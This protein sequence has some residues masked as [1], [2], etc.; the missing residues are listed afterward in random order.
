M[1][2]MLIFLAAIALAG[3][4]SPLSA[5]PANSRLEDYCPGVPVRT[6]ALDNPSK[7]AWDLF[8]TLNHPAK[9]KTVARGE[10]NCSKRIGTPGTTAVWETWRNAATEVYLS[11]GAEPPEW[12]DTSLPDEKPGMVPPKGL[13]ASGQEIRSLHNLGRTPGKMPGR[14]RPQFSPDGIFDNSGGFGE[15]RL[16]KSTY[17]FIRNQCLFS[18]EGQQ[19]YAKAIV[20][21]KK[22]P[23]TFPVESIEVKAAWLDFQ[24][25]KI[26]QDKWGTYYTADYNG[27]KYGLVALH[28]LTKDSPNWFWASFHHKDAPSNPFEVKDVYG[29]PKSL[30]GTVWEN[31]LLGG[32]QTDFVHPTGGATLLSDHYV[33]FGFQRSSC[34]TCHSTATISPTSSMPNAQQRALCTITPNLPDAGL[35]L[36]A[37]RKIIGQDAFKPGTDDLLTERGVP[38]PLWFEK[39][40]KPYFLQTDFVWSIPFRG[41]SEKGPPPARCIW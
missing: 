25:E 13:D 1:R 14:I 18:K 40:S 5:P 34:M 9:A 39:D 35:P 10:P 4:N 3:C 26:P 27:K 38:D 37:C 28:I 32:T 17:D 7:H 8:V 21:G 6:D 15:T 12:Q 31:Y 24:K 22:S 19:R 23:I 36:A 16:N 30:A 29:Q 2:L 41:R 20:D 33:E 11:D